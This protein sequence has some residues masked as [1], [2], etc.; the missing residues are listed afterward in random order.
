MHGETLNA[1]LPLPAG[2]VGAFA[3]VLT[4]IG[5]ALAFVPIPGMRA[6]AAPVRAVLAVALTMVLVPVWPERAAITLPALLFEVLLGLGAGVLISWLTEAFTMAMQVIG[7]QAGYN[8]AATID[9]T[10]QADS[11]VLQT[12]AQLA[13]SAMFLAAGFDRE[14]IRLFAQSIESNPPGS[15]GAGSGV[16]TGRAIEA[17]WPAVV[18]WTAA[19]IQLAFRLAFPVIGLL[20]M[21]DL[22]LALL[23][24]LDTQLQLLTV[25]F[26]LKMLASMLVLSGWAAT[27]LSVYGEASEGIWAPMR[28]WLAGGPR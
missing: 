25:A 27:M 9:P 13:G 18:E 21:V 12:M 10:T 22:T 8:Y 28:A 4:R 15:W 20:L 1:L 7:T 5:G 3:A 23:G 16:Q 17:L 24:R 19:M 11:T 26:P 14:L 2:A 6:A